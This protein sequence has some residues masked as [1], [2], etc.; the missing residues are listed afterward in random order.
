MLKVTGLEIDIIHDENVVNR[1]LRGV[2]LEIKPGETLGIVGETGCGKSLTALSVM[3]L[4]SAN[5]NVRGTIE[6]GEWGSLDASKFKELRGTAITMI[7][8][9]PQSSF[10][11]IFTIESQ[12][13]MVAFRRGISREVIAGTIEK[14]LLSVGLNDVQRV[15]KSYP[16]QLS[17]GM[18]QRCM[19]AMSLIGEPRLLIA[20]EPITALDATIGFQVLSLIKSLQRELGFALMFISHDVAAIAKVSDFVSVL[21][22]GKVVENGPSREVITRP[23]HPYTKGL[24]GSIPSTNK[25]RGSLEAI[26]GSVPSNLLGITGCAF[27]ERC[28]K[29][30]SECQEE[31]I[32]RSAGPKTVSCWKAER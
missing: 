19:I 22:A 10:N 9:N 26:K 24:L 20:D 30:D 11:P 17:G 29:A 21:Y 27:K 3:D 5:M 4:L 7:F 13:R 18:L 1:P 12:L 32:P 23:S 14:R 15:L 31:P 25:P 2:D 6:F 8:Q 28:A 16:H